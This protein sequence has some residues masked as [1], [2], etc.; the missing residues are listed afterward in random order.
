MSVTSAPPLEGYLHKMKTQ[1]KN[2]TSN[3][4]KR[5]FK[6]EPVGDPAEKQWALNYYKNQKAAMAAP[7]SVLGPQPQGTIRLEE[8]S[9]VMEFKDGKSRSFL[10]ETA[11]RT[12]VF[13]ANSGMEALSWQQ[14]LKKWI[15]KSKNGGR[16][17]KSAR[18]KKSRFHPEE[19]E[20][21]E[22]SEDAK[23]EGVG[24]KK[25]GHAGSKPGASFDSDS[26]AEAER[27]D[28]E[29]HIRRG[30]KNELAFATTQKQ[31]QKHKS[32]SSIKVSNFKST[33]LSSDVDPDVYGVDDEFGSRSS[34]M[35]KKLKASF[36]KSL[37]V[38]KKG[39]KKAKTKIQEQVAKR[40]GSTSSN[41]D[42]EVPQKRKKRQQDEAPPTY[43][44]SGGSAEEEEGEEQEQTRA[45]KGLQAGK[46]S[47]GQR[48]QAAAEQQ[49]QG[50]GSSS[51][52][53]APEVEGG[54]GRGG[55]R[56]VR[57]EP[58][59][60]K[61]RSSLTPRS[62]A[63]REREQALAS[64]AAAKARKRAEAS[65]GSSR[66]QAG[67]EKDRDRGRQ[68][69]KDQRSSSSLPPRH[70][71]EKQK[72]QQQFQFQ[73]AKL[74]ADRNSSSSRKQHLLL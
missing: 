36:T 41:P 19:E 35:G 8:I 59:P 57:G 2:I 66:S 26:N 56:S 28:A 24:A 54:A 47:S 7:T 74:S 38:M 48:R 4:N 25:R 30:G 21:D 53:E 18:S 23:Q 64:S 44:E 73:R 43:D 63:N 46:S 40:R 55:S 70:N 3:W 6:V 51:D 42:V 32:K 31:K 39:A 72:Q 13:R 17:P 9:L 15:G 22:D 49:Q 45:R 5:W 68:R 69:N 34:K 71:K 37:K 29:A 11:A 62:A 65:E 27:E 16:T 1:R 50:E 67:G 60:A 14:G 12:F 33:P 61:Q 58:K 20:E 52:G 10:L